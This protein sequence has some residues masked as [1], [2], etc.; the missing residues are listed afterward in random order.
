MFKWY[1]TIF[2]LW[3]VCQYMEAVAKSGRLD[4]LQQKPVTLPPPVCSRHRKPALQLVGKQNYIFTWGC[5]AE[6][7]VGVFI[8][9]ANRNVPLLICNLYCVLNHKFYPVSYS[10]LIPLVN[11]NSNVLCFH[12]ICN[13]AQIQINPHCFQLNCQLSWLSVEVHEYCLYTRHV[14]CT[15]GSELQWRRAI[16]VEKNLVR[17]RN[18]FQ[19]QTSGRGDSK[20]GFRW[21]FP[22]K[23]FGFPFCLRLWD[24]TKRRDDIVVADMVVD[25]AADMEVH[26]VAD[27]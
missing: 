24:L 9:V 20:S 21:F 5:S 26:M 18:Q 23:T 16:L 25:M 27:M 3:G 15:S 4:G 1:S 13:F 14:N 6:D 7:I 22:V 17:M 8:D 2:W 19:L 10:R 11:N 12:L